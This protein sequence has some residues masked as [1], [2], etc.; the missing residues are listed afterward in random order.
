MVTRDQTAYK[1]TTDGAWLEER[2]ERLSA[3]TERKYVKARGNLV[4]RMMEWFGDAWRV[5]YGSPFLDLIDYRTGETALP[6][7]VSATELLKG[8]GALPSLLD[9]LARKT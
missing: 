5:M 3:L 6:G 2:A 1:Q 7:S 9:P 4:L 8:L